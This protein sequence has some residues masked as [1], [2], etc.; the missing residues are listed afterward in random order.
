[1]PVRSG[2]SGDEQA[3]D[4]AHAIGA[5]DPMGELLLSLAMHMEPSATATQIAT[6]VKKARARY[7][8]K[9]MRFQDYCPLYGHRV[10]VH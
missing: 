7:A 2:R 9:A 1:M 6:I 8:G 3:G 4:A 5:V 10:I